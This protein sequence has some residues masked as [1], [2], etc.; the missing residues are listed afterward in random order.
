[1]ANIG[2]SPSTKAVISHFKEVLG[3]IESS[4]GKQGQDCLTE[5]LTCLVSLWLNRPY[6]Y[7]IATDFSFGFTMTGRPKESLN[8]APCK[9][10]P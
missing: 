2:I 7:L 5:I 3:V 1:M 10:Q 4:V 8:E 9:Y 6:A